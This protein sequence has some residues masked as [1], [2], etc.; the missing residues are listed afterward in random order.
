MKEHEEERIQELLKQALPPIGEAK[1]QRDL[2]PA[3]VRRMEAR[4]TA[5]PW[6]DWALA[7][8]VAVFVCAFPTAIPVL[9]Y[10]L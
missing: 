4:A 1:L 6:F 9:L 8:G 3:M 10:Y 5:P 2:W 7:A